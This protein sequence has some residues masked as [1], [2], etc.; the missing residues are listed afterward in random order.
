M[1]NKRYTIRVIKNVI[2]DYIDLHSFIGKA[3]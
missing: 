2:V 3:E 1:S